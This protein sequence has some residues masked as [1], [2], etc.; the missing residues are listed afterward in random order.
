MQSTRQ[1]AR[2]RDTDQSA[3]L[4]LDTGTPISLEQIDAYLAGISEGGYKRETIQSYRRILYAFY[5]IL[6]DDKRVGP[7]TLAI[8]SAAMREKGYKPRTINVRISSVNNLL[9]FL[10]LREYQLPQCMVPAEET[11]PEITRNEY[12]RLLSCAKTLGQECTYLLTKLFACTGLN[13]ENLPLL[14]VE[15]VQAGVINTSDGVSQEIHI[16]THLQ[17]ELTAYIRRSGIRT[18][19]VFVTRAGKRINRTFVTASIQ[20]LAHDARIAPEKCT[21]R[22]LRRLYQTTWERI[23][24]NYIPLMERSYAQLLDS[25]QLVIGWEEWNDTHE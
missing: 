7:A 10:G 13:V 19:P 14:T 1:K 17:V 4:Y 6:P 23:Q 16:P 12:L 9:K 24:T 25:E 20:R 22:S 11:Q 3:L 8:W 15:A 5:E 18:G 21:P 2:T